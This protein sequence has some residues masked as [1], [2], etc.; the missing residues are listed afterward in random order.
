LSSGP[1]I[2]VG[3]YST[4]G[5]K[6]RN[7]DSYGVL[8]PESYLLE[9]KGIAM[10]IADGMS[11][12]EAAK[13]ASE[14]CLKSFL[15]DYYATHASWTVKTSVGR[16]LAAVN[17]WLHSQSVAN[18]RSDRGMVCTFSGVVLKASAAH[19]FHAGDTRIYHLRGK[20][21]E[22][23]TR[24]HRTH[25][26]RDR[27]YLSKAIGIALDIEIDYRTLPVETG[28]VLIFTTDGV[29]EH[30]RDSEIRRLIFAA[31]GNLDD[32]ARHIVEQAFA[33]GSADNLTCQIVR[34]DDPGRPD[35]ESSLGR[36]K[37]LPF[38]PELAAGHEIDGF[39]I[40]RELHT[41]NRTQVYLAL[42]SETGERVVLK[43]P[44]VNFEDDP[45]YVE[46]FSREEWTGQLV[47]N[48]HVLKVLQARRPRNSLYYVTEY[49]EGSTLRQWMR[50]NPH[51]DL[52]VVRALLE[53]LL[54]GVR[55]FH[56][57]EIIHQDLKPENIL[58]DGNG[59][60]KIIDFG[61]ARIAALAEGVPAGVGAGAAG[62]INYLA[63]ECLRG[64]PSSN[65][66]DIFSL[67]VIVYE[68]L[69]GKL[70][71]GAGGAL[72]GAKSKHVYT[73]ATQHRP[74]LPPWLN[75]ALQKA[76]HP[77]PSQRYDALSAFFEDVKRPN[78]DFATERFKPL[79]ERNPAAFW[80]AAAIV[81][82]LLNLAWL[83]KLSQ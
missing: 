9:T 71:Y 8:M 52:G 42:D 47:A 38:P 36:V 54:K 15:N 7:D 5:R 67:G 60:V 56:R 70:P 30:L 14:T 79:L 74:E 18:Y 6:D 53:Q 1:K 24:D 59:T 28:D 69:T 77:R 20:T 34:V 48:P 81:L 25:V 27:N 62:T 43:T 10:A 31:P 51:P 41:S 80:R 32:A 68:M 4:A 65:R 21:I 83:F 55:A 78:P 17:S 72:Q 39:K 76:V 29:H 82:F 40:I 73:P 57:Q 63:P 58:V 22:Q 26:A 16:V 66:S 3:Q 13:A 46:M 11:S 35:E 75:A 49:V 2:S 12:S 23:L 33:N 64:E 45:A 44:S 50:D 19:V 61:S 37:T